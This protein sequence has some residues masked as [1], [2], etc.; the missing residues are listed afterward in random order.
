MWKYSIRLLYRYADNGGYY[1]IFNKSSLLESTT[2]LCAYP[3]TEIFNEVIRNNQVV[4]MYRIINNAIMLGIDLSREFVDNVSKFLVDRI[5]HP[6]TVY[7]HGNY[8]P[9][10]LKKL[11]DI[12][13]EYECGSIQ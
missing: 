1:P 12:L 10:E 4:V 5:D 2:K 7:V 8:T 13:K 9:G 6:N 11:S 3:S